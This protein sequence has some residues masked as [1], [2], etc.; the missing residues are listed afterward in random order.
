M[1]IFTKNYNLVNMVF[2]DGKE[3]CI[4]NIIIQQIQNQK[5]NTPLIEQTYLAKK[6]NC[7]RKTIQ[8]KLKKLEDE[9]WITRKRKKNK[10]GYFTTEFSINDKFKW[11]LKEI[12]RAETNTKKSTVEKVTNSIIP[13]MEGG[14]SVESVNF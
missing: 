7:D 3:C 2:N 8:R 5:T 13:Q 9:E 11:L 12:E 6:L 10:Q 14:L 1:S 4:V